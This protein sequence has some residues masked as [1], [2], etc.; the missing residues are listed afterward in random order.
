MPLVLTI[1]PPDPDDR[2]VLFRLPPATPGWVSFVTEPVS[3]ER[4]LPFNVAH[5]VKTSWTPACDAERPQVHTPGFVDP[6]DGRHTVLVTIP[7]APLGPGHP[8]AIKV[9]PDPTVPRGMVSRKLRLIV[10]APRAVEVTRGWVLFFKRHIRRGDWERYAPGTG[11]PR[12]AER[13]AAEAAE[14][15]AEAA[16]QIRRTA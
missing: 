3:R 12:R 9:K 15:E 8:L 5:V 13:L 1:D 16:E 6:E 14:R 7:L 10:D 4:G 11:D 2:E